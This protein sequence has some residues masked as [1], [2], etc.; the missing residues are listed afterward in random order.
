MKHQT[1]RNIAKILGVIIVFAL[2]LCVDALVGDPISRA[3]ADASAVR[4]AEKLY[5]GQS[6]TVEESFNGQFFQYGTRVQSLTS[7][8]TRFFVDTTAWVYTTDHDDHAR[9]VDSGF[10]TAYRQGEEAAVQVADLLAQRAPEL[11]FAP[12]YG[13]QQLTCEIDLGYDLQEN[14]YSDIYAQSFVID[15]AFSKELLNK[16]PARFVAQV[17]TDTTPTQEQMQTVLRRLKE[18]LESAGYPMAYYKITLVP[19]NVDSHDAILASIIESDLV[20]AQDI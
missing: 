8:D 11:S 2:I 15:T 18:V 1:K 6:F 12:V 3:M 14:G 9:V 7:T 16:V 19:T 5:P 13:T 17:L 20:S 10:N 4:Y